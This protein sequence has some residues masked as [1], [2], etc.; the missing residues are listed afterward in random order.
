MQ[1]T[2]RSFTTLELDPSD[3]VQ[4][5]QSA[6]TTHGRDQPDE[7][8]SGMVAPIG[9]RPSATSQS[10]EATQTDIS[11]VDI[12]KLLTPLPPQ[13]Y[14]SSLYIDSMTPSV[15]VPLEKDTEVM[16]V[17]EGFPRRQLDTQLVSS[18]PNVDGRN[19]KRFRNT[20]EIGSSRAANDRLTL[21]QVI[22]RS[23]EV[24]KGQGSQGVMSQRSS[25]QLEQTFDVIGRR[26]QPSSMVHQSM[27]D[28]VSSLLLQLLLYY[29]YYY[30][31]CL[32]AK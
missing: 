7:S 24:T 27:F 25:D 22:P 15:K 23:V 3:E 5:S 6:D 21:T 26:R 16:V 9:R 12:D 31:F 29:Y 4:S 20:L 19:Q 18:T 8:I 28:N 10:D 11:M 13:T 30:Y 17:L 32:S 2:S 14:K 1:L